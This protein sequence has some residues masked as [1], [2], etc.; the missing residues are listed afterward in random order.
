MPCADSMNEQGR[1]VCV[2]LE[3]RL[4]RSQPLSLWRA[5]IILKHAK[6]DLFA[7]CKL[8]E[9]RTP[10]CIS[11]L[12]LNCRINYISG[13]SAFVP[14]HVK[15]ILADLAALGNDCSSE[16]TS[17][18]GSIQFNG[19]MED[20]WKGEFLFDLICGEMLTLSSDV[21]S[22]LDLVNLCGTFLVKLIIAPC[23]VIARISTGYSINTKVRRNGKLY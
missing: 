7:E 11:S 13:A 4:A 12:L 20:E 23:I 16:S 2:L 14:V 1:E 15:I 19:F 22:K 17:G 21:M 8:I 6:W 9:S 10:I 18:T 5:V 3:R